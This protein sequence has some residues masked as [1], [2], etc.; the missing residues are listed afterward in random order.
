MSRFQHIAVLAI[1]IA[2]AGLAAPARPRAQD[3][4]GIAGW[5][6]PS[7]PVIA[8]P[9]RL[10]LRAEQWT[11]SDA[12][13]PRV[14]RPVDECRRWQALAGQLGET[15]AGYA[16]RRGALKRACAESLTARADDTWAWPWD[17]LAPGLLLPPRPHRVL[18]AWEIRCGSGGKRGRCAL[19]NVHALPPDD[20]V[21]PGDPMLVTHFVIDMVARR[22]SLLWRMFVPAEPANATG[23]DLTLE[24]APQT[25]ARVAARSNK[26]AIRYDVGRGEYSERFSTCVP[27]GCMME[28]NVRHAGEVATRLWEGRAVDLDVPLPSGR[29]VRV[30]LPADGFR[31]ALRELVRL[32]REEG[33]HRPDHR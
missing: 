25:P 4:G 32:R 15:Y 9:M 21:D 24:E 29:T 17:S 23:A 13:P 5:S 7:S 3:G 6:D 14:A 27:A 22:E 28:A 12:V 33:R 20:V 26:L 1:A 30:Q 31:L 10:G 8:A 2:V 19:I 18:G 16:L 11:G